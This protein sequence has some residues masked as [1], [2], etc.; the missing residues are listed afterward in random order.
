MNANRLYQTIAFLA[1]L[2]S[3]LTAQMRP[4]QDPVVLKHWT[5][6]PYWHVS[7]SERDAA[8]LTP[9]AQAPTNSLVF[10]GITPCRVVDT[11]SGQGFPGQFGPPSL[12][13]GASRTFPIQSSASCTI[14]SVAQAYS[15]NITV[16]P[17][18]PTGFITAY[19][20]AQPV[21]QA[22][23][24]VWAQGAITS[25]A[26]VVTGGTSGSIDV[27]TN[28][29]TDIVIDINGYYAPPSGTPQEMTITYSLAPGATSAPITPVA[30]QAVLVMGVQTQF[31]FWGVGQVTMLRVAGSFLAWTGLEPRPA[32][33]TDGISKT[34]GAH[35][36][37]L[38]DTHMVDLQVS[39]NADS[40]VVHNASASP[41]AGSVTL[42]W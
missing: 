29:A 37:F 23:T 31:G 42:I 34:P 10:V 35:I 21:P 40:F 24:L 38:D 27:F 25:N 26:A 1:L 19:P 6:P 22:A 9:L 17:S 5:A 2:A 8:G 30:G 15:F 11:R 18:T 3:M 13:P 39:N 33:I 14:P 41:A 32:S 36:L 7:E 4:N 28:S 12:I 20:T 16:V